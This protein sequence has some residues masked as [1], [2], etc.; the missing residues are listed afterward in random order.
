[1]SLADGGWISTVIAGTVIDAKP[2]AREL[3]TEV[4][5]TV[6]AKSLGGTPGAVYLVATPLAVETG[7]TVPHGADEQETVQ[8]TPLLAESPTTEAASETLA[9]AMTVAVG[10]ATETATEGMVMVAEADFALSVTEVAVTL[11]T[12][13][14]PA[15][16]AGAV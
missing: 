9:P 3:D 8:V 16:E 11:T 7:E 10:G 6:T 12:R 4:A 14:L 5:V 1:M 2:I 13:L 15:G